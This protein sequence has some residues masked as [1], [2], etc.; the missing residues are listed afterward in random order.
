MCKDLM[1]PFCFLK[2]RG[3]L[4]G[5]L[6]PGDQRLLD[7]LQG[8][9]W[10]IGNTDISN[11]L[12]QEFTQILTIKKIFQFH[13]YDNFEHGHIIELKKMMVK[14]NSS[15]QLKKVVSHPIGME[16]KWWSAY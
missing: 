10:Q 13:I 4:G 14:K 12:L 1:K 6:G 16:P 9:T 5:E 8:K 2:G 7:F 15:A 3:S 11:V